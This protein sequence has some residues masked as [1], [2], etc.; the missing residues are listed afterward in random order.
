V[1]LKYPVFV[2]LP[3]AAP[4][5]RNAWVAAAIAYLVVMLYDWATSPDAA[6]MRAPKLAAPSP[7]MFE[8]VRCYACGPARARRSWSPRTT[9]P[10][11]PGAS[12]S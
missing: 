6:D 3:L 9:S 8:P 4:A 1:L 7:E 12:R 2:L 10:A 11:S 5:S